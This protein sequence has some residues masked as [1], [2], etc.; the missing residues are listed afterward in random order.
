MKN[1][2]IFKHIF[3]DQQELCRGIDSTESFGLVS[4]LKE[5][6]SSPT[7]SLIAWCITT[8]PPIQNRM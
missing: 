1:E 4:M 6:G 5:H 3:I 7:S 8:P 2:M